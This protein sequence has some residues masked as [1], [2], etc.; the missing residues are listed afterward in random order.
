[1]WTSGFI[2]AASSILQWKILE[3]VVNEVNEKKSSFDV[4]L[5]DTEETDLGLPQ[6]FKKCAKKGKNAKKKDAKK[7]KP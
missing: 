1:M 6:F 5:A 7:G 4:L 3:G 2:L